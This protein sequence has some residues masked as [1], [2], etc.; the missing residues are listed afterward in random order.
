MKGYTRCL[1]IKL[2]PKKEES[3]LGK[4]VMAASAYLQNMLIKRQGQRNEMNV[5]VRLHGVGLSFVDNEPKE[6]M[7]ISLYKIGLKLMTWKEDAHK[8]KAH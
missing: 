6:L 1:E 2:K 3:N 5:I 4:D 7:Y 8:S